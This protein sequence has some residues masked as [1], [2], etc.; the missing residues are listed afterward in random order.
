MT[1]LQ[2]TIYIS[3]D[4]PLLSSTLRRSRVWRKY[5]VN[6]N[7]Y[8][9]FIGKNCRFVVWW[10]WCMIIIVKELRRNGKLTEH[11][12]EAARTGTRVSPVLYRLANQH[13]RFLPTTLLRT[14]LARTNPPAFF[15]TPLSRTGAPLSSD[16]VYRIFLFFFSPSRR[17]CRLFCIFIPFARHADSSNFR[18]LKPHAIMNLGDCLDRFS[19]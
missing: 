7:E 8:W 3:Y 16:L 5:F 10:Q 1:R 6:E 2:A 12:V 18:A 11:H 19:L 17:L 13:P 15:P 9:L 14:L 4:S